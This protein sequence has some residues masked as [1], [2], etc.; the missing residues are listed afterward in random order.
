MGHA[1]IT[2]T[3]LYAHFIPRH[4]AARQGTAGLTTMLSA[5]SVHPTVHRTAGMHP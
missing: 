5:R 4:D 2:T 3:E 1:S